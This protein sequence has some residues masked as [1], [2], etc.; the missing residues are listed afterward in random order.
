MSKLSGQVLNFSP[1]SPFSRFDH[2]TLHDGSSFALK[3]TLQE[4]FPGRFGTISPAAVE[5]HVT[6]DLLSETP[7][8]ITLTP[9]TD[10]EVHHIPE[11]SSIT[12]GLLLADRMFF[13]KHYL[14]DIARQGGH[15]VVKTR[16]TLNPVIRCAP[17]LSGYLSTQ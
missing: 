6:M 8:S 9:D 4:E 16:G 2:I 5:L 12:G 13:I 7:Q 17:P 1:D 11:A 15:Y 3:S 10:A 14:A